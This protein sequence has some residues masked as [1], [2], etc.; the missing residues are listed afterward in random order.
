M[1]VSYAPAVLA[2]A[3]TTL[4][5]RGLSGLKVYDILNK[6]ALTLTQDVVGCGVL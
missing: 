2:L 1:N 6:N 4:E 5:K 3:A